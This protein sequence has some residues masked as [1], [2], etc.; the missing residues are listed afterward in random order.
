VSVVGDGDDMVMQ[1]WD[2][3]TLKERRNLRVPSGVFC[4]PAFSPDGQFFATAGGDGADVC[5]WR[6]ATGKQVK[7]FAGHRGQVSALAFSPDGR[8][9]ASGAIDTTILVWEV[10]GLR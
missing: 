6:T 9:L 10:V 3:A 8:M 4:A 7:C 5:V 1:F 2:V